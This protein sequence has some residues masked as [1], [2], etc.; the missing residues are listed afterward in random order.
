MATTKPAAI[1]NRVKEMRLV[2]AV[3]LMPNPKNYRTHPQPQRDALAGLLR[4]IGFAGAT[5]AR[6]TPDGLQL[7]DGHLRRDML[8]DQEIPVLVTDLN[9]AEANLLLASYDPIAALAEADTAKL[10]A[11]LREVQTGEQDLAKMLE[12]L[13]KKN[14]LDWTANGLP[15]PGAGGDEFDTT[16]QDGPTRVQRGDLWLIDGGKHRL[17][18]GDSMKAEDV[19]RVMGGEK[20]TCLFTDPP[21]GVSVGA[22]NR[23]LNSVQPSGRCL[24][25]IEDDDLSPEELKGQLLA[26]FNTVFPYLADDCSVF[27]CSPQGGGL[28]MMM[29]MMMMMECGLTARHIIIWKKNAPTFSMGRL[30]YDYQH[31][32][33]LFAWK[34]THKRNKSGPHQTSVWEVDKLRASPDHATQKPLELPIN[35]IMNHTDAND[36]V[37]DIYLGSGTTLIAAHRLARRCFGIE[38][39]PK[40]CDVILKRATA[41]G[42]TV[43]KANA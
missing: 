3:D 37:V 39:E 17:L 2:K 27:V 40:Y 20:A 23:L 33:I 10:D 5:L 14:K 21:Y 24:A 26:A 1:R 38:I 13:A 35:A 43:E 31:E 36:V 19:Q 22:K 25:D 11:L 4:E 32:P 7:I 42:L 30:D 9:E 8:P 41:E 34:K 16:P 18:C 28:G 29:M 15:T 6:E 12:G